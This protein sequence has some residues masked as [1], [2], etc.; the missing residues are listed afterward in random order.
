MVGVETAGEVLPPTLPNA[1]AA[2]RVCGPFHRGFATVSFPVHDVGPNLLNL[3]A[4]IASTSCPLAPAEMNETL[5]LAIDAL[6]P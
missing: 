6:R 2:Q 3:Y 4:A 5:P 1:N